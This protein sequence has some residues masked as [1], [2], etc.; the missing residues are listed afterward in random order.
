MFVTN[1]VTCD[2][3]I[4]LILQ[5]D[6]SENELVVTN[7]DQGNTAAGRLIHSFLT[8]VKD[9]SKQVLDFTEQLEKCLSLSETSQGEISELQEKFKHHVEKFEKHCEEAAM[10]SEL[11]RLSE[12]N[13]KLKREMEA[14]REEYDQ[15]LKDLTE[16]LQTPSAEVPVTKIAKNEEV[17]AASATNSVV[18]PLPVISDLLSRLD[19][20]ASQMIPKEATNK[21]RS[22]LE[23]HTNEVRTTYNLLPKTDSFDE[24]DS[25][26]RP[27]AYS[28]TS[29]G[30][31]SSTDPPTLGRNDSKLFN[32][33]EDDDTTPA[34]DESLPPQVKLRQKTSTPAF[35]R[36]QSMTE[37]DHNYLEVIW[38]MSDF[39]NALKRLMEQ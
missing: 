7:T 15:K 21:R 11:T 1:I 30:I 9:F 25:P 18:E 3:I 13:E 26:I 29:S 36:G 23:T 2:F 38:T 17:P 6:Q 22:M 28:A 4:F 16:R 32:I 20:L 14:M 10:A 31:G 39:T 34:A 37:K 8:S 12:E 35:R 24:C 27:R 19:D 5:T 33:E